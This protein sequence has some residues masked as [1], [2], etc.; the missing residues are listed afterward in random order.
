MNALLVKAL[1]SSLCLAVLSCSC[2]DIIHVPR[3]QKDLGTVI[4][5]ENSSAQLGRCA[6][7]SGRWTAICDQPVKDAPLQFEIM[8][9]SCELFNL[10]PDLGT[11]NLNAVNDPA[12]PVERAVSWS[13]THYEV[14]L[15]QKAKGSDM[16]HI[17]YQLQMVNSLRYGIWSKETAD[18]TQ[19][20]RLQWRP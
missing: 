7:F 17:R 5:S 10:L 3:K 2:G 12:A 13:E 11:F 1:Q 15:D 4:P 16:N 20:C 6:N 8:Q 9:Q 18:S 19:S 14:T